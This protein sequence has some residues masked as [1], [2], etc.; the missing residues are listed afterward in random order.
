M[1]SVEYKKMLKETITKQ[2]KKALNIQKDSPNTE[3]GNI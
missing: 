1:N 3:A 2:Y